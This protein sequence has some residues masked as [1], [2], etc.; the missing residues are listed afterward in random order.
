MHD[1]FLSYAREDKARIEPLVKILESAG[2]VVWWDGHLTGGQRWDEIIEQKLEAAK[3]VV[4]IWSKKSIASRWVRSEATQGLERDV[5]V[6]VV[7]DHVTPP[8]AFKLLQVA[9]LSDWNRGEKSLE[10]Q[11]FLNAVSSVLKLPNKTIISVPSVESSPT[12]R[13]SGTDLD[14]YKAKNSTTDTIVV[15]RPRINYRWLA[16][17]LVFL[18]GG[19]L[20]FFSR[21]YFEEAIWNLQ[22]HGKPVVGAEFSD[23]FDCPMMVVVPHGSFKMGSDPDPKKM[24]NT[25][26]QPAHTVNIGKPFAIGKFEITNA[27][28]L[29]FMKDQSLESESQAWIGV[30]ATG[31]KIGWT[32]DKG[33]F[34]KAGY[35][36]HPVQ[37]VSWFGAK[38]YTE[39]LSKRL[40]NVYRLPS[41]AEW[42]YAARAG[43]TSDYYFGDN[44][45]AACRF[46]NIPDYSLQKISPRHPVYRCDDGFAETAPVGSFLANQFKLNDMLGNVWEWAEDCWHQTY[47]GAP[48][49]GSAW[50]EAACA[51]RVSRGGS[52]D[53]FIDGS[54][55]AYRVSDSPDRFNSTVGF[56]IV[57]EIASP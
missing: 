24:N 20:L 31:S 39:W 46:A 42:E 8:L 36:S 11:S 23:C 55:S 25:V 12:L 13:L 15:W 26:Q 30:N 32:R 16:I 40:G 47:D 54:A 18:L 45:L 14:D 17:A 35:E 33:Y 44:V 48:G 34:V 2:W 29:E 49:D 52:F 10:L 5:L 4:V 53:S 19:S 1:I 41:E 51:R 56:R 43:T 57:R 50:V 21:S 9:N 37:A 7:F 38:R 27:Q 22:S 3:C 6:P 28:F